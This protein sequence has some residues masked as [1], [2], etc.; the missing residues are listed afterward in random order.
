M[1]T[2]ATRRIILLR[3]GFLIALISL[4]LLSACGGGGSSVA[5]HSLTAS[6]KGLTASGLVLSVNGT[7]VSVPPN[8]TT[9]QLSAGMPS[10]TA[11]RP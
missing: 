9:I 3:N 4:L 6:V 1:D 8:A 2:L 7:D 5:K 10:G 11:I